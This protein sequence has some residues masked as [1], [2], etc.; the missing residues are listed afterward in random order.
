M[1]LYGICDLTVEFTPRYAALEE[2]A[3]P[4][5]RKEYIAPDINMTTSE[6]STEILVKE[7][8]LK[9]DMA[10][11][12]QSCVD[13][14][15][16][17]LGYSGFVLHAS[18][19]KTNDG[20]FLFSAPSGVGKSTHASLWEKYFGATVINDDKPA[21]RMFGKEAVAYGTPWC[22]SGFVRK[23]DKAKVKALYFIK[24]AKQN[25]A[26][27]LDN[28]TA[29]YLMLESMFRPTNEAEMDKLCGTLDAFV[30]TV[31]V[32]GLECNISEEAA[33]TAYD[34]WRDLG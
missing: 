3:A 6:I 26:F 21:I 31:P 1:A 30:K 19:V 8:A 11:Y 7:S 24:R 2:R 25:R 20:C 17:I 10:E 32:F 14:C 5:L 16:V 22:G 13:F 15:N 23:N 33:Q 34:A 18:A 9:A 27:R 12:Q 4:F 28:D 29:V